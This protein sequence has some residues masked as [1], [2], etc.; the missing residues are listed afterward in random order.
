MSNPPT[1][2]DF[3][4][5]DDAPNTLAVVEPK[6]LTQTETSAT[7]VAARERAAI[8]ARYVMALRSPREINT[9]RLRILDACKRPRFAEAAEY[10]KPVG[11]KKVKGP[12]IRLVEEALRAWGNVEIQTLVVFD[13]D[14][15]RIVRVSVVDLETNVPYATDVPL[16]KTVE[17]RRTK[18]GDKVLDKRTNSQ[19]ETTYTIVADEDTFL[20]KQNAHISKAIRNNGL[21]ILPSDIIEEAIDQ[22]RATVRRKDAEDPKAAAKRVFDAFWELGVSPEQIVD[23]LG[24]PLETINPTEIAYLRSIYTG[25]KD[26]EG[27]WAEVM[28]AKMGGTSAPEAATGTEKLRDRVKGKA[29]PKATTPDREP[30]EEEISESL[31][32]DLALVREEERQ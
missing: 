22:A 15:R 3:A 25:I 4:P 27:T 5:L 6:A 18:P 23:F 1:A 16:M 30:T 8:E 29:A 28:T 31:R 20:V 11:D 26:G 13:D 12:S 10:S 32:E 2:S 24:H 7:A 17:R 19:G 14:T 21:R 9:A